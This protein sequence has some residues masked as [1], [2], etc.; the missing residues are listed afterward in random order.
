M[1]LF[2]KIT[3]V[4]SLG[5]VDFRSDKERIARYAK[6]TRNLQRQQQLLQQRAA[7]PP[8]I[9]APQAQPLPRPGVAICNAG[10]PLPASLLECKLPAGHPG[11]HE[12]LLRWDSGRF[13]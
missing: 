2:R 6:Q 9:R 13:V 12:A 8:L 4:S 10:Q 7:Q 3:S 1:G 5:A 11:P